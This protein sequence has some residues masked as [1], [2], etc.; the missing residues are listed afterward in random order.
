VENIERRLQED[1]LESC[2]DSSLFE[3][4]SRRQHLQEVEAQEKETLEQLRVSEQK[5]RELQSKV[6]EAEASFLDAKQTVE[7]QFRLIKMSVQ[8]LPKHR[9]IEQERPVEQG[10]AGEVKRGVEVKRSSGV[11]CNMP[12]SSLLQGK[13]H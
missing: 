6:K 7:Q 8:E 9:P 3:I 5:V 10:R 11:F 1:S 2:S 12:K 4:K 13:Q